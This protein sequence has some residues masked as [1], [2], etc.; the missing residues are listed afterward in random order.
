MRGDRT[1]ALEIDYLPFVIDDDRMNVFALLQQ[2]D[3]DSLNRRHIPFRL[4][5]S[6]CD[7]EETYNKNELDYTHEGSSLFIDI[8]ALDQMTM[9]RGDAPMTG[10]GKESE[11]FGDGEVDLPVKRVGVGAVEIETEGRRHK[12]RII[13]EQIGDAETDPRSVHEQITET[14]A[15]VIG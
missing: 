14:L 7:Q 6:A 9:V 8:V 1:N 15:R 12:R 11:C 2:I 5:L 13:V 4:R 3:R 10:D